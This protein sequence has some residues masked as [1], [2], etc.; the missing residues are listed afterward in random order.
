[1]PKD[2]PIKV[3][4]KRSDLF[5]TL[6]RVS[7]LGSEHVEMKISG[8]TVHFYAAQDQIGDLQDELTDVTIEGGETEV[9]FKPQNVLTAL[10]HQ[11]YE[12][13]DIILEIKDGLSPFLITL[14]DENTQLFSP[15]RVK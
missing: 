13:E 4:S 7:S 6:E 8:K 15:L 3:K 9:A 10:K 11:K 14:G 12:Q 5:S 2:H 1:M